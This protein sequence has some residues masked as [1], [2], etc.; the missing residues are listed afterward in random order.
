MKG[1]EEEA[2]KK[3]VPLNS[4][5]SYSCRPILAVAGAMTTKA[6]DTFQLDR[7]YKVPK[8]KGQ[9][10]FPQTQSAGLYEQL[11]SMGQSTLT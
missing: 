9:Y 10:S 2:E 7:M 5:S 11:G 3:K 6:T 4:K 8:S 1:E